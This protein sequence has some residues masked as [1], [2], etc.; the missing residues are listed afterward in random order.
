MEQVEPKEKLK[1]STQVDVVYDITREEFYNNYVDKGK[2]V[3]IKGKASQWKALE[4][5][6]SYFKSK[7]TGVE[8]AIKT[9]NIQDGQ[10]KKVLLSDYIE[11]LEKYE[12]D[13]INNKNPKKP[14]YLHDVP[15]FYLFPQYIKDVEPFPKELFPKFYWPE[16]QN[17]I[18]F[19]MGSTGSLTPLHFD[20]LLTN[21]LFFQVVG[22]KKFILIDVSGKEDCYIEGWRWAKFDPSNPDYEKF[23]N[24]KDLNIMEVVIGPGDI[25]YMPSGMLHQVHGLSRSI[26]F[27]IDWH[28]PKTAKSGVRTL[29]KGAP[30]KNVYY[31]TI[32][33][34]AFMFKIPAKRVFPFYKSYLN[35]V[36]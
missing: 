9:G 26:S 13:L 3:V 28:T 35:Y 18:Q 33:Y 31:N 8:L 15:F 1:S 14:G 27:N 17:Y 4:W 16:W 30:L 10:R 29:W 12:E 25:L 24:A 2:A 11:L 32:L 19:F 22:E 5:D 36:S 20:T 6:S 34:L 21:N 7:E 23:P